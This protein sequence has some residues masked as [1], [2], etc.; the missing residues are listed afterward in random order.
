MN[1]AT[2][3]SFVMYTEYRE[4]IKLLT[5]EDKGKLLSAIFDY[6]AGEQP[7]ISGMVLMAFSFIRAQM[8]RD[9]ASYE[10]KIAQR[11]NAGKRGGRPKKEPSEEDESGK[12]EKANGFSDEL[13][14]ANGFFGF[15]EKAKKANGF[16]EKQNNPVYVDVY[17]NDNVYDNDNVLNT[18]NNSLRAREESEQQEENNEERDADGLN[19]RRSGKDAVY[20]STTST[21]GIFWNAY[22]KQVGFNDAQREWEKLNINN[23]QLFTDIMK[24]LESASK[25]REWAESDGRFIPYPANFLSKRLWKK[26]YEQAPGSGVP[27]TIFTVMQS[28][29][30][31]L[32]DLEKKANITGIEKL[33]GSG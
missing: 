10:E 14:K 8:D 2:R 7:D 1:V 22:P 23:E 28:H 3:N 29:G 20:Q 4:H 33:E 5:D 21:F 11:Q 13:K 26:K 25:S 24:G 32:E 31:D 6:A 18:H 9:A 27:D 17:V 19:A 30:W 12:P 15:S 16:S